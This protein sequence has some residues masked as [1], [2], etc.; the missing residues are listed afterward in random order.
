MGSFFNDSESGRGG[1]RLTAFGGREPRI[2]PALYAV[3]LQ[4]RSQP[5]QPVDRGPFDFQNPTGLREHRLDA[6]F[7]LT[8][9]RA[10]NGVGNLAFQD[11][12]AI[13]D[14]VGLAAL[15][16]HVQQI[17]SRVRCH[18]GFK[19]DY[20]QLVVRAALRGR[21]SLCCRCPHDGLESPTHTGPLLTRK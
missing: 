1:E 3:D 14:Q 13:L 8:R 21:L 11:R 6:L 5:E 9:V 10:H 7:D 15:D 4:P 18:H 12:Q 17:D 16:I 20:G 19:R 2:S